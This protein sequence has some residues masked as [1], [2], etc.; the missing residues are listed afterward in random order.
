MYI[1]TQR[2]QN[3]IVESITGILTSISMGLG[4]IIYSF[5]R[6]WRMAIVMTG[7][8]PIML[9]ATYFEGRLTKKWD[10]VIN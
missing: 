9:L 4:G 10:S 3:S 7:F 8:L 2:A 1:Q 5:L 6:G